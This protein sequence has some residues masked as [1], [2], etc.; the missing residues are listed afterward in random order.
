MTAV[1]PINNL[2]LTISTTAPPAV[3]SLSALSSQSKYAPDVAPKNFTSYP[4]S[5]T[6]T[7]KA[8]A[9]DIVVNDPAAAVDP[10]I[11]ELSTVPPL[12]ASQR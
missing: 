12:I 6:P 10:P 7:V 5:S 8:P 4:V 1:P 2:S 9:A 3:N 11:T